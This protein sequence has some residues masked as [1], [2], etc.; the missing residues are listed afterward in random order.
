MSKERDIDNRADNPGAVIVDGHGH[1]DLGVIRALGK[2]GVPVYLLSDKPQTAARYSR[3]VELFSDFPAGNAGELERVKALR[4]FGR[5]FRHKPV[6]FS[7][8]DSTLMLF[9]RHRAALEHYY[10]HHLAETQLVEQLYDKQL[11]ARLAGQLQLPI[12]AT[13]APRS[14]EDL[15]A[16]LWGM[17]F[18]VIVKPAEKR[19][20]AIYPQVVELVDGNPKGVRIDTRRQL[21]RFYDTVTSYNNR[22]IIQEYIEGRDELL[23]SL[24]AYIDRRHHVKAWGLSQKIRT[25]PPHRG[26]ATFSVTR[27]E[28]AICRMGLSVLNTLGVTGLAILQVKWSARHNDYLLLEINPR[29]G[30]SIG[31]YPSAGVN[32]PYVAYRDSLCHALPDQPEQREGVRWADWAGDMR[33]LRSYQ[34]LGEWRWPGFLRSYFGARTYAVFDWRDPLPWVLPLWQRVRRK[35]AKLAHRKGG[36]AK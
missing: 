25:N 17:R 4:E 7:T 24:Y 18:P 13:V 27:T 3:Y 5:R 36:Y 32:L 30:T 35:S 16:A 6:L 19:C 11:F 10:R 20:W 12:P 26:V 34:A 8:G 33:A 22:L 2:A 28:R 15:E 31:L 9:S 14:R 1:T 21:L 23:Y 29:H